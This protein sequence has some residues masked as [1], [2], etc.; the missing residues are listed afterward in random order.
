MHFPLCI[1]KVEFFSRNWWPLPSVLFELNTIYSPTLQWHNQ[2]LSALTQSA[3]GEVGCTLLGDPID[4]QICF[5]LFFLFWLGFELTA[6]A[7]KVGASPLEPYLRSILLLLFWRL[8]FMKQLLML[9]LNHNPT[10]FS[11]S[12]SYNCKN[13]SLAPRNFSLFS[14]R[15]RNIWCVCDTLEFSKSSE[16]GSVYRY[17]SFCKQK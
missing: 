7:D 5:A 16:G 11:L 12:S 14:N 1:S 3:K 13:E 8:C 2:F 4:Y 6:F 10:D 9:A 15:N 17:R